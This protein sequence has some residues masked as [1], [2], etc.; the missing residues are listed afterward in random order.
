MKK[1]SHQPYK[2]ARLFTFPRS[3]SEFQGQSPFSSFFFSKT[4]WWC[5]PVL[6][7]TGTCGL[8]FKPEPN[9]LVARYEEN[10][11]EIR[12]TLR[13]SILRLV[14]GSVSHLAKG[15]YKK[16]Q[17]CYVFRKSVGASVSLRILL[18]PTYVFT[19]LRR[20]HLHTK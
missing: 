4:L 9:P 6:V 16:I 19:N 18:L 8:Y 11:K 1:T 13:P 14:F 20:T 2:M 17:S 7:F 15:T 3:C 12:S 10:T 5:G